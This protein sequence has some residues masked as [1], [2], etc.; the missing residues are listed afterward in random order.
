MSEVFKLALSLSLSGSVLA[1]LVFGCCRLLGSRL[2][3][4]FQYYIWLVVVLR[5]LL[6]I[7]PESSI[8]FGLREIPPQ[9]Q[10]QSEPAQIERQP[11]Q[12]QPAPAEIQPQPEPAETTAVTVTPQTPQPAKPAVPM[13]ETLL[14]YL[15]IVWL[16]VAAGLMVR[17]ITLYQSFVKYLRAGRNQ[18]DDI[19]TLDRFSALS[20]QMGVRRAIDLY[21]NRLTASPLILGFRKVAVVL[22]EIPANGEEFR[23][24]CLHELT[25]YKRGDIWYKW[26]LQIVLCLHWFNP[27]VHLMVREVNRL[28]ELSCDEAVLRA[29]NAEEHRQYGDTLLHSLHTPGTYREGLAALTLNES[30]RS[31]KERLD[32]I[33]KFTKPNRATAV[34]AVCL[35]A[36]LFTGGY[37]LGAYTVEPQAVRQEENSGVSPEGLPIMSAAN[38]EIYEKYFER[39]A[40][41]GLFRVDFSPE[42]PSAIVADGGGIMMS[43]YNVLLEKPLTDM[44]ETI[45][46]SQVEGLLMMILNVN[47]A[48]IR[49]AF[50]D[51]YDA[52]T[53]TYELY[54]GLGGGPSTP[55]VT[56]S[57][58]SG[59]L[60]TVSYTW[61][62]G[63]PAADEFRYAE[64]DSGTLI[65]RL[66][67]DD[68]QYVSNKITPRVEVVESE[69]EFASDEITVYTGVARRLMEQAHTVF[70]WYYSDAP[71]DELW[72]EFGEPDFEQDGVYYYKVERF[73]TMAELQAA[74]GEVF[75]KGFIEANLGEIL[76][77]NKFIEK[78][79]AL[80]V[81]DNG[82]VP[83]GYT[84]PPKEYILR[85]MTENE[86][87][88]TA[89]CEGL[90]KN[91]DDPGATLI[92]YSFELVLRKEGPEDPDM[93]E[94]D[95]W[96]ADSY[97]SYGS[98]GY[99]G[100]LQIYS[101]F[102]TVEPVGDDSLTPL[103]P[104]ILP[105]LQALIADYDNQIDNINF[106]AVPDYCTLPEIESAA[107]FSLAGT[108]TGLS[109]TIPV[110]GA[111]E[112]QMEVLVSNFDGVYR[113]EGASFSIIPDS[114]MG[115]AMARGLAYTQVKT[116]INSSLSEDE[117]LS[118]P[119]D[120]IQKLFAQ[121]VSPYNNDD[122][123]AIPVP[124]ADA[125]LGS[126]ENPKVED[127]TDP[128]VR[129]T[130]V[131]NLNSKGQNSLI[132]SSSFEAGANQVLTL[133]IKSNINGTVDFYLVSP[134]PKDGMNQ[135]RHYTFGG[136][137]DTKTFRL[138]EG[139][140]AYN[141][142]GFFD[143][144]E[145]SIVG[146]VRQIMEE[147]NT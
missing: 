46:A 10:A 12:P 116:L 57:S 39:M 122:E 85:S 88:L 118:M 97:Y 16:A 19:E 108:E 7:S 109:A 140:W 144:G 107:D 21:T 129:G 127:M 142:T 5:L 69:S 130:T 98:D 3:K 111:S 86:I 33:M 6:P 44:P 119:L 37:V 101:V 49:N 102:S 83:E 121:F 54:G 52:S 62:D 68:Y 145:I 81:G 15:W 59:D 110:A 29:L 117:I 32:S 146:T 80:Y 133:E 91:S 123:D 76:D 70:T 115:K 53:D 45:P 132:H 14:P 136:E 35:A 8:M 38:R 73:K 9:V 22:P 103:K 40:V 17:K 13:L 84:Y 93:S 42:D 1:V 106:T 24:I 26:L 71:F 55:I 134:V 99:R 23:L 66:N 27:V 31:L 30:A 25:H 131:I 61:Y 89:V 51:Y 56:G 63:D 137:N 105:V 143:S 114:L 100:D 43:V 64:G 47:D 77:A 126:A 60:L 124:N 112:W 90:N 11:A 58:R 104:E 95:R 135:T 147:E 94:I 28:C 82:G 79:G 48:A 74:T 120:E 75:T 2:S 139:R 141:C 50:A 34:L 125:P 128:D 67:K 18:V 41:T 36:L 92:D 20:E 65:I 113:A 78:D 96:R 87:V 138:S 4:R 72:M